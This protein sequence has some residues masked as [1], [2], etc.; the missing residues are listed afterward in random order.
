MVCV[1]NITEFIK[2]EVTLNMEPKLKG[3]FVAD[4]SEAE[5]RE[6]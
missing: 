4:I 1:L 6:H 3:I 5:D 2:I